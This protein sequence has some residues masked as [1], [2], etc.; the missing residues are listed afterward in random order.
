MTQQTDSSVKPDKAAVSTAIVDLKERAEVLDITQSYCVSAPAGSGKTELLTQ[1]FLKLLS[2]VEQP[3]QI[4]AITFTRKAAAEM[5]ERIVMALQLGLDS[6]PPLESHRKTTWHLARAALEKNGQSEWQLLENPNR[7]RLQTI[8]SLCQNIAGDL[9]LLSELGGRLRSV[10]DAN[11]L[12][13]RAVTA[14]LSELENGDESVQ[15]IIQQALLHLDNNVL[16]LQRLLIAMLPIR[17]QWI[18]YTVDYQNDTQSRSAMESTLKLWIEQEMKNAAVKLQ[19]LSSELCLCADFA[20][21]QL[22]SG[23]DNAAKNPDQQRIASLIGINSLPATD[24]DSAEHWLALVHLLCTRSGGIRKRLT[25]AEGFPAK[26]SVKDKQKAQEFEQFKSRMMAV[27]SLVDSDNEL[28][29]CLDVLSSL[30]IQGYT[31]SDWNILGPLSQCLIR[32]YAHLKLVFGKSGL[33]DHAEVTASALRALNSVESAEH[34][35]EIQYRWD[36]SLSHILVDEFQDTSVSQFQLLKCLTSEWHQSNHLNPERPKTLFIV[37]DGMQSIYSFRA[38]KV[39]LFLRAKI[40]G[41]GDLPVRSVE[42]LQNFRSDKSIVE[43]N[44]RQFQTAFPA[45]SD[46]SRGA[47]PY[48]ASSSYS[49]DELENLDTS[50]VEKNYGV[51]I[52]AQALDPQR[53]LE[54]EQVVTSIKASRAQSPQASVAILVRYRS[55]LKAILPALEAAGIDWHGTDISPLKQR[56]VIVDL[57]SLTK[58]LHNPIDELSWVALLRGP[59]C[60]LSLVDLQKLHDYFLNV[61]SVIAWIISGS[62]FTKSS[63]SENDLQKSLSKDGATRLFSFVQ[64]IQPHWQLRGKKPLRQWIEHT[65]L[66]LGGDLLAVYSNDGE[67]QRSASDFFAL[68]EILDQEATSSAAPFEIVELETRVDRLYASSGVQNQSSPA[69]QVMTIHKS[70]GLEFDTVIIPGLDRVGMSDDKPIFAWSEHLF[71][72]GST[73][74]VL[75]PLKAS[76]AKNDAKQNNHSVFDFLIE[77]NKRASLLEQTRLLYVGCTRAKSKLFLFTNVRVGGDVDIPTVEDIRAPTKNALIS[78]L[79]PQVKNELVLSSLETQESSAARPTIDA[80]D[81]GREQAD[82]LLLKRL[83]HPVLT[84][85]DNRSIHSQRNESVTGKD[86]TEFASRET[87]TGVTAVSHET[88]NQAASAIIGTF[89]HEIFEHFHLLNTESNTEWTAPLIPFWR[90]RLLDMGLGE[91][92]LEEGIPTVELAVRNASKSTLGQW[93]LLQSHSQSHREWCLTAFNQSITGSQERKGDWVIDRSFVD[94]VGTRWVIDYKISRP[95]ESQSL[96]E[97]LSIQVQLYR[98]QM[99]NYLNLASLHDDCQKKFP[100]NSTQIVSYKAALYFPLLDLLH[101]IAVD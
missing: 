3:E 69:V 32:C 38:A 21:R 4:L 45:E 36:Q 76:N 85:L 70:K 86:L 33:S 42:L 19:V 96:E 1:R 88:S 60:G 75:S 5:R 61:K 37:G 67:D 90:I 62:V 11:D 58:A 48:V 55:H 57:L 2:V 78:R 79:W 39:G 10:D 49:N 9:P 29:Q 52:F 87:P 35:Q 44:N 80:K 71:P 100:L 73:G 40:D 17:D 89:I 65:W 22:S 7:L 68:L 6:N 74:V 97:F 98:E 12:Y 63:R 91:V 92:D 28:K 14:F 99:E 18:N 95:L 84:H 77:E 93:V 66:G 27:L 20:A 13:R 101:E 23:G 83:T 41:V 47:V 59:C 8:D 31:K 54:A 15:L 43:W 53:T 34:N 46:I 81:E 30:P 56:E 94:D 26:T 72:D 25:K 50:I 82:Y 64:R 24:I 51:E 16:K